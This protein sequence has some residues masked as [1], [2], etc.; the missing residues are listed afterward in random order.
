[1]NKSLHVMIVMILIVTLLVSNVVPASASSFV[2]DEV[3]VCAAM[4]A[5]SGVT[6]STTAQYRL[7]GQRFYDYVQEQQD[8]NL[9]TSL[10]SLASRIALKL[11][12]PFQIP[13][14]LFD[15]LTSFLHNAVYDVVGASVYMNFD[16]KF[17][18]GIYWD[19]LTTKQFIS[20]FC[21]SAFDVSS[22]ATV[23]FTDLSDSDYEQVRYDVGWWRIY[24]TRVGTVGDVSLY[25][26]QWLKD[27][28]STY[29]Y[30]QLCFAFFDGDVHLDSS[31]YSKV[32]FYKVNYPFPSYVY[33]FDIV[34][35]LNS[36]GYSVNIFSADSLAGLE[37]TRSDWKAFWTDYGSE[38]DKVPWSELPTIKLPCN[39]TYS[40]GE[41]SNTIT[42][43][44]LIYMP[45]YTEVTETPLE[46]PITPE[47]VRK[48]SSGGGGT[49]DPDP[50]PDPEPKPEEPESVGDK[51]YNFIVPI[52]GDIKAGL[53]DL[54]DLVG[55]IPAKIGDLLGGIGDDLAGIAAFLPT[56][57]GILTGYTLFVSLFGHFLPEPVYLTVYAFFVATIVIY[58][59]RW[60][61]NR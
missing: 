60:V 33:Y 40:D 23:S 38:H 13:L 11:D 17:P 53:S 45:T 1:M 52:L 54:V 3:D 36:F 55:K 7:A 34:P 4:L 2:P 41:S 39:R 24:A 16:A 61:A 25:C 12:S 10:R 44:T 28:T 31:K 32:L 6:F 9:L 58:L 46:K 59:I 57:L 29:A 35:A 8:S 42:I 15:S 27:A 14:P 50:A 5:A 37:H 18:K 49:T 51:I 47:S 26:F 30:R 48:D 19:D 21:V 22:C 43:D 20:L 56:L